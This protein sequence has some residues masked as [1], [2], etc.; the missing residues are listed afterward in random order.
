MARRL[1]TDPDIIED[2][3]AAGLPAHPR[4]AAGVAAEQALTADRSAWAS[5]RYVV[6][7]A[8]DELDG[9]VSRAF[10]EQDKVESTRGRIAS[11]AGAG[12]ANRNITP[13]GR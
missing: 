12:R 8:L 7:S 9:A 3:P 11:L 2:G 4:L 6:G 5:T 10:S 13:K 1:S